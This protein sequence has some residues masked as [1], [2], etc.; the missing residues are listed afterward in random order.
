LTKATKKLLFAA[1]LS[2]AGFL[3]NFALFI[4]SY[5]RLATP[6]LV[7]EQRVLNADFIMT[8]TLGGFAGIAT[9]VGL[10]TYWML[11]RP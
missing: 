5:N 2:F 7:E 8:V 10:I 4:F 3:A 6:Y 9:L 11:S 1:L